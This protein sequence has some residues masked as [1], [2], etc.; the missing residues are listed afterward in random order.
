MYSISPRWP[1]RA[2]LDLLGA[3]VG[4]Y[5]GIL[6]RAG[7]ETLNLDWPKDFISLFHVALSFSPHDPL[8]GKFPPDSTGGFLSSGRSAFAVSA[9]NLSGVSGFGAVNVSR[10]KYRIAVD[11]PVRPRSNT[12]LYAQIVLFVPVF[13]VVT[14]PTKLSAGIATA[15]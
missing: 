7:E 9:D 15:L 6:V 8:Y 3:D 5:N 4:D 14:L 2:R 1:L 13:G 11:E 10:L 12:R